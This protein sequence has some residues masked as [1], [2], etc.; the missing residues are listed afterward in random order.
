MEDYAKNAPDLSDYSFPHLDDTKFPLLE[1]IDVYKYENEFDYSRWTDSTKIHLCNVLW[2]ND[3]KDV[4]KFKDNEE[5]DNY[6]N[7][8]TAYTIDLTTAFHVAPD[9]QV[10]VPVPY[11]V[12][13][14]Y[15]YLFVDLPIMT[16]DEQPINYEST[17]R[18][19]RY[20]YFID[21]IAQHSPNSTVLVVSPDNWTTYINNVDIPYLMLE[22]GHAPMASIDVDTYLSNP[23]EY[24]EFLL[25]PDFD[26]STDADGVVANSTFVPINNG[27][28]Y[29]IFATTMSSQQVKSQTYPS[30]TGNSTP[31]TF[32]NAEARDGWQYIVNNYEWNFGN[33]NYSG[34]IA[35]TTTFQTSNN[36]IPNGMTLIACKSS[37]ASSLFATMSDK[38]PFFYKTIQACF[39]VDDTMFTKGESFTFCNKTC[40]VVKPAADSILQTIKLNKSDFNY[41]DKYENITKLYTSPYAHIEITD[42]NGETRKFKIENTSNIE[43]RKATALAFPY[44]SI[45]AYITGVNGS[46]FN[47]YT[48][49]QINDSSVDKKMYADDF[50][51]YLW[52]MQIPTYALFVRGYDEYKASNFNQQYVDR[53]N[54]IAEYQK[55]V[56]MDNTQYENAND[57][58]DNT[59][60]MTN[61]SANTEYGNATDMNATIN[62]NNVNSANTSKNNAYAAANTANTNSNNT[63][64][65]AVANTA[66]DVARVAANNTTNLTAQYTQTHYGCLLN[67]ANQRWDAGLTNANTDAE[68]A[69]T[70]ATGISNSIGGVMNGVGDV[71]QQGNPLAMIGAGIS[72]AGNVQ[73]AAVTTVCTCTKNST[74]AANTNNNTHAKMN[75]INQNNYDNYD[76]LETNMNTQTTKN[77]ATATAMTANTAGLMRTNAGNTA[78]TEKAN[79]DRT[80]TTSVGN[81]NRTKGT[82]DGN[83]LR[84]RNNSTRNATLNRNLTVANS[85]YTRNRGVQNAKITLEQKRVNAQYSYNTKKL[86]SPVQYGNYNGD[87]TLDAFERRGLQVK[88][89][90]QAH[91]NIAQTGDLMLRYGYAF[92][93]VWDMETTSLTMMK[94]FTYWKATDIWINQGE[95]VNGDAQRDIQRAFEN[96]VTIWNNPDEI[97]KVSI[98]DN[99]K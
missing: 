10:K 20:Y 55:T 4:V 65:N 87:M 82:S 11:A 66:L 9:G 85:N 94:H 63:A 60:V 8:L 23:L 54:A 3:Y 34:M 18:T 86:A 40:Y 15:N 41:H 2:N 72:A 73:A 91:G 35:E 93:Q 44:I 27:E 75:E 78:S 83:A 46:G 19:Q 98:Y 29:I 64:N 42:N 31:A 71:L 33:Y 90:T 58:A 68:N 30:Q 53:Y 69:F 13:T 67:I 56:G 99:W 14:R 5:R 50:G 88:V 76:I 89:R 49:K 70:T 81:A 45:Q 74:I 47:S 79:A 48:W 52:D 39:M 84:T 26:F 61:N 21:G 28:K 37:D 12:A 25:A 7:N 17:R 96:G 57:A 62:T 6:F 77:N 97:G 38:I 1:N 92:N 24:N 32:A 95:G 59:Q 22:R 43:I 16:S 80:N 51:E 36:A